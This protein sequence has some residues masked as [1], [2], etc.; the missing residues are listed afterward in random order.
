MRPRR[1]W[2][3]SAKLV[4][5]V[6]VVLFVARALWLQWQAMRGQP[7]E[8]SP[9]WTRIVLSGA[10]FLLAHATL[11]QTWRAMLACWDARLPFWKAAR[12]W[13]VSNLY[14]YLPG[15]L[16]QVGAMGVMAQQEGVTATAAAATAV[17]ST[18]VNIAAGIAIAL[19]TGWSALDAIRPGAR[20]VAVVLTV[21][22]TAG[23]L[24]LP[25]LLPHMTGLL[26]RASGK[27]ISLER[28]PAR[29]IAYAIA[30]NVAAWLLYGAAFHLFTL[31]VLGSAAGATSSYIAVYTASYVLG[32]L[33]FFI[34]GGLGVR[35][36]AVAVA[37]VTLGL[38]TL[39]QAALVAAT[40]RLWLTLLEL[41]PGF[42][43]LARDA[44]RR[45]QQPLDQA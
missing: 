45:R 40:S 8:A 29:A 30:G 10:L 24:T 44:S 33:A 11:V 16:W 12:I 37:L 20:A 25:W 26:S 5:G 31:G 4:V 6:L 23:L 27:E 28:L 9:D 18:V 22:A 43:F 35:E 34:P 3:R 41:V 1:A 14:R 13:S 36:S 21:A 15:K 19:A 7:L 2:L 38:T 39:P 32:Y 17:L 42:L